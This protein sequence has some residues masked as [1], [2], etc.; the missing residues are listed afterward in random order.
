MPPGAVPPGYSLQPSKR[1]LTLFRIG[2]RGVNVVTA[3]THL[4]DDEMTSAQ[5]A[6]YVSV[7]GQGAIDQRPG[8][9]KINAIAL[10]SIVAI[11]NVVPRNLSDLTP[12]L[13]AAMNTAAAHTWR[14]ST[15][16]ITW[17]N[18][19]APAKPFAANASIEGFFKNF[20][21]AVTIGAKM[22]YVD[23]NAPIQIHE[24]NG[25]TDRISGTI[26][27]A[28]SGST[29]NTPG[30]PTVTPATEQP[31]GVTTYVYKIVAKQGSAN[32]SAVSGGGVTL[33]GPAVFGVLQFNAIDPG[34][35]GAGVTSADVYR[36]SGGATQGKIGNIPV[37]AGVYTTGNGS[38]YSG[39]T[40]A[41]PATLASPQI[42]GVSG[43]TPAGISYTY[44]VV[45]IN[46]ATHSKGGAASLTPRIGVGAPIGATGPTT[47]GD[48]MSGNP[49]KV[50]IAAVV[51][52]VS[53]YD[54][55]R[56][57]GGPST[58]KIG[59]LGVGVTSLDDTGQAGDASVAPTTNTGLC[60]VPPTLPAVFTDGGLVGDAAIPPTTPTGAT[61][62][63]AIGVLD[64]ITDGSSLLLAVLDQNNNDPVVYGRILQYFP[65]NNTWVQIGLGFPT[66]SG[67]G[68]AAALVLYDGA[69]SYGTYVGIASGAT[70][71]MTGTQNPLPAGGIT[72]VHTTATSLAT[73]CMAVF[74]GVL[75]VGTVSLIAATAAL[76]VKRVVG[77]VWSTART[78]PATAQY[79][80]Y[81]S[82][83]VFNGM[84]FA[85]WTSGGG[86]TAAR[87]ESTPD[88]V[89]WTSEIALD[90]AEVVCQMVGFNGLLYAVLGK[91]GVGYNTKSRIMQ[92]STIGI[93]TAVDDP[94]DDFAGCLGVVYQ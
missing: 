8:M 92:R 44:C 2:L 50:T 56:V 13:Y 26:P 82:M 57:T 34:T 84:L 4:T 78:G 58:G 7:A 93:W 42:V 27:S 48:G 69:L 35:P 59:T 29:L 60:P 70:S 5:N 22:Y 51:D 3:P 91:T 31:N 53:T 32:N 41:T 89:T 90:V 6:E 23:G 39:A 11:H 25:T 40:Y 65:T 62:A 45:Q 17:T 24:W 85:G 43:W 88:G 94:S 71:Y 68:S 15:D 76:I 81:T 63:N 36:T 28:V 20:P 55:Y 38:G 74:Q 86:A 30:N 66:S 73:C 80:A 67:S 75:Y 14:K 64:M 52:G 49:S 16:G 21:K 33:V 54:V 83:V 79:N 9:T 47:W 46:G 72:E 19:D 77:A 37:V 12:T 1:A 18:V 61:S 10:G 87:I